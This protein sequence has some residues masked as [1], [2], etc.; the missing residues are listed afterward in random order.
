MRLNITIDDDAAAAV[1]ERAE[2]EGITRVEWIRRA[3]SAALGMGLYRI[4]T[5]DVPTAV[6]SRVEAVSVPCLDVP[7]R[8]EEIAALEEKIHTLEIVTGERDQA[9]G[10]LARLTAENDRMTTDLAAVTVDPDRMI[11]EAHEV[12]RLRAEAALK[13]QVIG[14][15]ADEIRWLRGEV[16]KL[17]DKLTPAALPEHAGPGRRPWWAFWRGV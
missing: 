1:S 15:R 9:I 11:I 7:D 10:V 16:N 13:D 5:P 6:L 12:E 17:N 4:G 14:E 2:V 8:A 3:V